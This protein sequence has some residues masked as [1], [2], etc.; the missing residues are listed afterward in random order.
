MNWNNP[1]K[2]RFSGDGFFI[3]QDNG[4]EIGITTERHGITIAGAGSG[5]GATTIIPNIKRWKNNLLVIDPKGENA[6]ETVADREAMGQKVY[7]IDPFDRSKVDKKYLASFN[8]MAALDIHSS[9]VADDIVAIADGIVMRGHDP[10]SEN[11]DDGA[12]EL[13]AGVIAFSLLQ[14]D[15][16]N[17]SEV[18]DIISEEELIKGFAETCKSDNRLGGL[19]RAGAGRILAKEGG[20]YVSNAQKNTA[21][22]D[23]EPIIESLSKSDFDLSELK[24]DKVSVYLVLPANYLVS[25]GR[26]LRMFVRCSIEEMARPTPDGNDRGEQCLFMLDEFFALGFIKEI[27]VSSGLMR[28]YGLQLWPIMQDLGQL[29]SLYGQEGSQ[30]FFANADLHQFFGV[31]DNLTA[32]YVSTASGVIGL[33][34][35]S[36][37]PPM[38]PSMPASLGLNVG[39]IISSMAS[40][41]KDKNMRA[42]GMLA[43]GAASMLG[44]VTSAAIQ[45]KNQSAQNDYQSAMNEYQRQISQYGKPR[46]QPEEIKLLT[47][48]KDDVVAEASINIVFGADR[49]LI[50]P[51]PYF[52]EKGGVSIGSISGIFQLI[53]MSVYCL[54]GAVIVGLMGGLAYIVFTLFSNFEPSTNR[55]LF[56]VFVVIGG[57]LGAIGGK[58]KFDENGNKYID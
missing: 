56:G 32:S 41:S 52:R 57:I 28:G 12:Q 40:G 14:G 19:M 45:A 54:G 3:G 51:L 39:G 48:K 9:T 30:T 25:Y 49:L 53:V 38:P 22:L 4:K 5:K 31:A 21:W 36:E 16:K 13:I 44:G 11:W 1:K 20:Y 6:R 26:F 55:M 33:D 24:N 8:P 46:L 42:T 15:K 23:R 18:R 29:I 43:G 37:P 10:S 17:L 50:K 34:E 27:A 47:Q 7:V 58:V 2:Y 35:L